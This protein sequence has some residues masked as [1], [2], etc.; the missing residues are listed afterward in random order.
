MPRLLPK[1]ARKRLPERDAHVF[2]GVVA[3]HREVTRGAHRQ[4]HQTV[5][6]EKRQH[7]V[8]ERQPR[9]DLGTALPR[10]PSI[11]HDLGFGGTAFQR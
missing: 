11:Q 9:F 8:E 5:A 4:V 2:N 3:V 7:V 10:P 1:G 6:R